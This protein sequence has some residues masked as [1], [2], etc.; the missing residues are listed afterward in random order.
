[1]GWKISGFTG[2]R[3]GSPLY[4]SALDNVLATFRS[5]NAFDDTGDQALSRS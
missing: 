2:T 3:V 4:F 1:V 5:C